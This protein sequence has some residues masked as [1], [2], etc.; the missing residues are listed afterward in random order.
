MPKIFRDDF[1]IRMGPSVPEILGGDFSPKCPRYSGM[2]FSPEFDH[3]WPTRTILPRNNYYC[4]EVILPISCF[5]SFSH[6]F[7]F[8][9]IYLLFD[10]LFFA[11]LS[12]FTHM[13]PSVPKIFRDDLFTRM[14]PSVPE[15]LR[16]DFS[17]RWDNLCP[18]FL[19]YDF[20]RRMGPSI[21][22]RDI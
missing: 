9:Y 4:G 1:F 13:G 3:L 11:C 16:V 2:T 15:I 7:A 17:P 21:C 14:R 8:A 18:R 5:P 20:F 12:V 19:G 10:L 6:F 22:A